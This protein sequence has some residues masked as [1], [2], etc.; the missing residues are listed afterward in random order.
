VTYARSLAVYEVL[1]ADK[2]VLTAE[3]L[4]VLEGSSADEA[5]A[6]PSA[7]EGTDADTSGGPSP[8]SSEP[9]TEATGDDPADEPVD[10]TPEGSEGE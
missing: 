3:A 5:V 1:G 9:S 2:V 8:D 10:A 6:A 4:D 7:V